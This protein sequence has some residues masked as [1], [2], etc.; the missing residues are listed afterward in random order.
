LFR[1]E[2]IY[3]RSGAFIARSSMAGWVG[4]C[5]VQLEPL[6]KALSQHLL[7]QGVL[8]GDETPVKLLQPGLGKTHQAYMWA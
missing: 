2:E 7:S 6:A 1:Q 3:R 8:H 5:G 4:Q